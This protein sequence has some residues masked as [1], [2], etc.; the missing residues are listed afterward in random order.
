MTKNIFE[1][2]NRISFFESIVNSS[3]FQNLNETELNEMSKNLKLFE[4]ALRPLKRIFE[5]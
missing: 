3:F 2:N 1:E 4:M 5:H